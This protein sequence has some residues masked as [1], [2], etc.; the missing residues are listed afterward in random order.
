MG[1]VGGVGG[2]ARAE[3][4]EERRVVVVAMVRNDEVIASRRDS[5]DCS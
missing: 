5:D 4:G 2:E 1:I 3:E